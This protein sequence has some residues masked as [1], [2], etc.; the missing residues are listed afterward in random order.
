MPFKVKKEELFTIPNI[1]CYIR[2][3]LIPVFCFVFLKA[4]EPKDYYWAAGI[5]I[6][7]ALTDALDGFLARTFNMGTEWGK[8]IDPI[9]DKLMQM[10]VA[11]CLCKK[12]P[13][14]WAVVA[15]L[16]IKEGYMGYMG[17]RRLREKGEIKGALWFGK[18]C[19]AL[20]F[21]TFAALIVFAN[22]PTWAS[23]GLI[24]LNIVVMLMVLWMYVVTFKRMEIEAR[25]KVRKQLRA[26]A[27]NKAEKKGD[28]AEEVANDEKV[29]LEDVKDK[30]VDSVDSATERLKDIDDE[31]EDEEQGIY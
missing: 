12:Y 30:T 21:V 14:M 17:Y 19:T 29:D 26:E 16:V 20:L 25:I 4:T 10:A 27:A 1:L 6:V 3:L 24:I 13:L 5:L 2:F 22:L 11:L 8:M 28:Q 9:I 23:N 31:V 7:A 15:L 18:V